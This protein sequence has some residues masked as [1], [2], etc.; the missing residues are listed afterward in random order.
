MHLLGSDNQPTTIHHSKRKYR[1][2]TMS[3]HPQTETTSYSFIHYGDLYSASSRLLFRSAPDPCMAK[4]N[5]FKARVECIRMNSGEQ[6]KSQWK[7]IPHRGAN[8]KNALV[9]LVEV[10]AKETKSTP[11][12]LTRGSCDLWCP[13]WD[14]KNLAGRPEQ[15]PADTS[16]PGQQSGT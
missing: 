5:S 10:L 9:F 6:S 14:S 1:R 2:Q 8:T 4:E 15:G 7:P 3:Y 11:F 13:G 16:R 12:P